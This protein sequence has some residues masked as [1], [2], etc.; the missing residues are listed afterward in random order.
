MALGMPELGLHVLFPVA[1]RMLEGERLAAVVLGEEAVGDDDV[2]A[3]PEDDDQLRGGEDGADVLDLV[4]LPGRLFEQIAARLQPVAQEIEED[5]A[6]LLG[7]GALLE[8]ALQRH[9]IA[10]REVREEGGAVLRGEFQGRFRRSEERRRP[11]GEVVRGA[12]AEAAAPAPRSRREHLLGPPAGVRLAPADLEERGLHH[13]PHL[14]VER[15]E[16][17]QPGAAALPMADDEGEVAAVLP[18][19]AG[20]SA[21]FAAGLP[22]RS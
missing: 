21:G 20:T 19:R 5:P 6:V 1:D 18:H 2:P 16:I 12:G 17:E 4:H 9:L 10:E 15:E 13:P 3:V 11:A 22:A 7:I 14:G 8:P